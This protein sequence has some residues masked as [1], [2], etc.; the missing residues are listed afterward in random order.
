VILIKW[1]FLQTSM[2]TWEQVPAL[3]DGCDGTIGSE[4]TKGA[5]YDASKCV[6]KKLFKISRKA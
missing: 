1:F 4:T 3:V 2:V 6:F 5:K